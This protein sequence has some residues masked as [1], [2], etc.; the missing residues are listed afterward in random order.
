[1]GKGKGS[2][3]YSNDIREKAI[4][5]VL[6]DSLKVSV[7]ADKYNL[8]PST[9]YRWLQRYNKEGEKAFNPRTVGRKKKKGN[10]DYKEAYE[11]VM[12]FLAF[13]EQKN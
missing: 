8:D 7:V 9:L 1:M 4:K 11:A 13:L 5:E 10:T 6:D 3:N 12:R 2:K